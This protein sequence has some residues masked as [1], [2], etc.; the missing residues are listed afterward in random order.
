M[1]L[2]LSTLACLQRGIA[3]AAAVARTLTVSFSHVQIK[4]WPTQ[5][6]DSQKLCR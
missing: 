2:T 6:V 5:L 4:L 1:A 3:A